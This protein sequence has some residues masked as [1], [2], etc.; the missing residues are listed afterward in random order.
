MILYI[1][2]FLLLIQRYDLRLY[3]PKKQEKTLNHPILK[4]YLFKK[5]LR[6]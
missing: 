3:S 1:R 6:N 5:K 2:Y 4:L